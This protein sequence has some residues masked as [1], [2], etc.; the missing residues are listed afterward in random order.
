MS[1]GP[2]LRHHAHLEPKLLTQRN[3]LAEY[4]A[5]SDGDMVALVMC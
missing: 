4:I 2:S 3:H 5:I 1:R